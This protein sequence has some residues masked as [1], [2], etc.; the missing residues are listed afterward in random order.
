MAFKELLVTT[1]RKAFV[2]KTEHNPTGQ[3]SDALRAGDHVTLDVGAG[4][5]GSGTVVGLPSHGLR[6]T[7]RMDSNPNIVFD[8]GASVVEQTPVGHTAARRLTQVDARSRGAAPIGAHRHRFGST[9]L[10]LARR[11]ARP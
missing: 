1:A 5:R 3:R 10:K 2:V 4:V 6:V 9:R 7:V 8:V 11:P